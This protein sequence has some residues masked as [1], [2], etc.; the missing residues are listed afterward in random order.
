MTP[1][2]MVCSGKE[3]ANGAKLSRQTIVPWPA[4]EVFVYKVYSASDL[5]AK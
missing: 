5:T 2:P 1:P 3:A 4:V